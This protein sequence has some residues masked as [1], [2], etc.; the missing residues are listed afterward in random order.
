M[1]V[2]FRRGRDLMAG[3]AQILHL[4]VAAETQADRR[5]RLAIIEPERAQHMAGAARAA[6][7]GGTQRECYAAKVGEQARGI[8]AIAADVEIALVPAIHIAVDRPGRAERLQRRSPKPLNMVVVAIATLARELGRGPEADA[9]RG[10]QGSGA[11][12]PLLPPAM[13]EGCRLRSL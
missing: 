1:L 11:H 5:A 13:N 3:V 8:D 12:A 9:Q 4:R 10:R 7:A 2:R 6:R